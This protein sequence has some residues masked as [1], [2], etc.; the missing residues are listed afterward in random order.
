MGV[1]SPP[2]GTVALALRTNGPSMHVGRAITPWVLFKRREVENHPL[3]GV[4][5]L[6]GEETAAAEFTGTLEGLIV[7][8]MPIYMYL[9]MRRVYGQGHLVTL[10]KFIL[11]GSLY[12]VLALLGFLVTLF[13]GIWYA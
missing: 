13:A 5:M 6:V 8:W 7:A 2:W 3:Q 9:S 4:G 11:I 10:F 1:E 12:F